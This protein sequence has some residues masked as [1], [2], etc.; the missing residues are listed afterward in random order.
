MV[1]IFKTSLDSA[2]R[3]PQRFV[4]PGGVAENTC[5]Y[6]FGEISSHPFVEITFAPETVLFILIPFEM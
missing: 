5:Q 2:G 4:T 3:N 1:S 6:L